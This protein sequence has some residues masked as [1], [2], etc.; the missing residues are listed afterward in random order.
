[1]TI[2]IKELTIVLAS[3]RSGST[4]LCQD[5]S[6]IGGLGVPN[7]Y[8]LKIVGNNKP[9]APSERL[10]LEAVKK[11]Q[12]PNRLQA[13]AIKMMINQA[14]DVASLINGSVPTPPCSGYAKR[15]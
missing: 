10:V 12:D 2:D 7:E 11:G 4:L 1:M 5:V 9:K 3:Q 14:S 6:A 8:F 15:N 13:G